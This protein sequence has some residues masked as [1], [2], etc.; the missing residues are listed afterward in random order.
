MARVDV[1][2][3]RAA[4]AGDPAVKVAVTKRWL[5]AVADELDELAKLRASRPSGELGSI[6]DKVFGGGR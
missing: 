1:K 2:A 3:L 4:A 5:A 6:F